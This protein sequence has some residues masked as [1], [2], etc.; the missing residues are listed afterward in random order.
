MKIKIEKLVYGGKGI[1][2]INNKVYFIPF[3]LSDEIVE[4]KVIKEKKKFAEALPLKIIKSSSERIE[5]KCQYFSICGGCDYQHTNYQNQLEIKK[6]IFKELMERIGKIK[7]EKVDIISSQNQFNYRNRVQFKIKGNK[8]GFYK[9]ES[10]EIVDIK[11]CILLKDNLSDL[12]QKLKNILP[13]MKF[14]PIKIHFFSSTG[15]EVLMKIIFPKKVK[16]L[17]FD[18][19]QIKNQLKIDVV[20]VGLYFRNKKGFL[21]RFKLYRK[22]FVV[23]EVEKYK[24]RISMDSFFQVN[25]YQHKNLINLIENEL[26]N[27]KYEKIADLYCGVG[28]LTFPASEFCRRCIGIEISKSAIRDANFNK[29]LNNRSN[30][31][32]YNLDI[33][34]SINLLLQEKPEVIIVD[35]P[36][37]GLEKEFLENVNKFKNLQ[38][39][40]Y[41]SCNPS[42]LAR[43][44]SKLKDFGFKIK[45]IKLI[46]MFPQTYHIES[47]VVLEKNPSK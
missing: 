13:I 5:P 1:G 46:D 19:K 3:V 7:I 16:E 22:E 26:K 4:I 23:E 24:Y 8:I 30:I 40:I 37:T 10:N 34:N 33:K 9:K 12:P 20:G 2:R 38:K 21:E 36:R 41:I 11:E 31:D 35:P 15:N 14:S 6:E 43:D 42:T 44:L 47:F 28:L 39:I 29:K 32:F 27:Q 25:I 17:P 45:E 18:L